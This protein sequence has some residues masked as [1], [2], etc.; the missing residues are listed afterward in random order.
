MSVNETD[1]K[2]IC[3]STG[4]KDRSENG[5]RVGRILPIEFKIYESR[6]E[7]VKLCSQQQ[8]GKETPM[9]KN[10][11]ILIL[12][13]VIVGT[14]FAPLLTIPD[15]VHDFQKSV[16]DNIEEIKKEIHFILKKR[17]DKAEAVNNSNSNSNSNANANAKPIKKKSEHSEQKTSHIPV[18]STTADKKHDLQK[19][20][21]RQ[22]IQKKETL[23]V[24]SGLELLKN[25]AIL[26]NSSQENKRTTAGKEITKEELS[27]LLS[28]LKSAQHMLNESS[29]NVK[30]ETKT[31][32][33]QM[34]KNDIKKVK[35]KLKYG[36]IE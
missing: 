7:K 8:Q 16:H 20:Q 34:A 12:L 33:K 28:I 11:I 3:N 26:N 5:F 35:K 27:E 29:F 30:A 6:G 36:L 32:Y 25:Q 21:K 17:H 1:Q 10:I 9:I 13:S 4:F 23:K 14:G 18:K 15:N 24:K 22:N 2:S 31:D 19:G